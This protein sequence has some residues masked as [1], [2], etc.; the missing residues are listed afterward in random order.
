MDYFNLS[1]REEDDQNMD[2]SKK[3]N[4]KKYLKFYNQRD[5]KQYYRMGI[6]DYLQKYGKWKKVET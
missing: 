4:A 2:M 1:V 3:R 5:R 6:I